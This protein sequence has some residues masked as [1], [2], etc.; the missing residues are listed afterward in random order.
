MDSLP[1]YVS[2]TLTPWTKLAFLTWWGTFILSD[3][4][5]NAAHQKFV[6]ANNSINFARKAIEDYSSNI[7]MVLAASKC[8]KSFQDLNAQQIL[9]LVN[10]YEF[11][12]LHRNDSFASGIT[13]MSLWGDILQAPQYIK[14]LT[15]GKPTTPDL[16]NNLLFAVSHPRFLDFVGQ[17]NL[18]LRDWN[19]FALKDLEDSFASVRNYLQSN[20]FQNLSTLNN[21]ALEAKAKVE[22]IERGETV[23]LPLIGIKISLIEFVIFAGVINF[24][25]TYYLRRTLIRSRRIWSIYR[26]QLQLQPKG[27]ASAYFYNWTAGISKRYLFASTY[28]AFLSVTSLISLVLSLLLYLRI[29]AIFRMSA[30]LAIINYAFAANTSL[31]YFDIYPKK[32]DNVI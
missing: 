8:C 28:A 5:G 4:S 9:A 32:E 23:S 11:D 17:S 14:V 1:E 22:E 20:A 3:D 29:P 25:I 10:I 7:T 26:A 30:G 18:L 12:S 2:S 19:T 24:I 13:T 16:V 31:L 27:L 6:A 21:N 15:L